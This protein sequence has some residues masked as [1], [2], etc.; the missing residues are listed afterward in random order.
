MPTT[1]INGFPYPA[2]SDN[3]NGPLAISNLAASIDTKMPRGM[4]CKPVA[5]SGNTGV[6]GGWLAVGTSP[7]ITTPAGRSIELKAVAQMYFV[8]AIG[9]RIYM[10]IERWSAGVLQGSFGARAYDITT[11]PQ[12]LSVVL[13]AVD[14]PAAGAYQYKVA[15]T[16]SGTTPSEHYVDFSDVPTSRGRTASLLIADVGPVPSI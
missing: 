15:A 8:G 11:S 3:P 4:L 14:Q 2:L 10:A 13:D 16:M 1:S 9:Q 7:T 5:L 6:N 12:L